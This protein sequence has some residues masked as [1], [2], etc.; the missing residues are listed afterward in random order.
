[1]ERA[2]KKTKIDLDDTATQLLGICLEDIQVELTHTH[3]HPGIHSSHGTQVPGAVSTGKG[4]ELGCC[5]LERRDG[6][7]PFVGNGSSSG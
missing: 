5:Q 3:W 7:M 2:L 1:M 6:V 4:K